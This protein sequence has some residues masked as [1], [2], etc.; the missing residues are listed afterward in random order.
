MFS[1]MPRKVLMGAIAI[2]GA[3]GM[4]GIVGAPASALKVE[5]QKICAYEY[6]NQ[7]VTWVTTEDT[8]RNIFNITDSAFKQRACS[9]WATTGVVTVIP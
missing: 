7:C 8:C 3:I 2:I 9:I 5:T 6:N 1:Y 4:T